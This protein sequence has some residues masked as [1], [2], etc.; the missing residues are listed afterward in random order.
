MLSS[1]PPLAASVHQ[2]LTLRSP[3]VNRFGSCCLLIVLLCRC[4]QVETSAGYIFVATWSFMAK[5]GPAREAG[6]TSIIKAN[7]KR[8]YPVAKVKGGWTDEEDNV[9]RR[10]A[11]AA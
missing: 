4:A 2:N 7:K 10:W 6:F 3:P 1:S 11:V 5:A 8:R 9:L